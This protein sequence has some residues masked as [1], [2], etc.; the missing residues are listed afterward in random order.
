MEYNILAIL[1]KDSFLVGEKLQDLFSHFGCVIRTR[2]GLNNDEKGAPLI[3][4][5]LYGDSD[6]I[7]LFLNELNKIAGIEYKYKII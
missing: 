5:D 7:K 4:M 1:V 3:I 6:Q 2:L